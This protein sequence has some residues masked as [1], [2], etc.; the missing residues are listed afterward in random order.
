[1]DSDMVCRRAEFDNVSGVTCEGVT[2]DGRGDTLIHLEPPG[3]VLNVFLGQPISFKCV[4]DYSKTPVTSFRWTHSGRRYS[5][6][7]F[8]KTITSKSDSDN[9][10]CSVQNVAVSTRINV[11]Y[12]PEVHLE[13]K[14][15]TI[16]VGVGEDL[17]VQCVV[18]YA[19]PAVRTFRWSHNGR[20]STG[21]TFLKRDITKSDQGQLTCT[22]DNGHMMTPGRADAT[23]NIKY[24]QEVHLEPSN[25]FI[26]VGVGEDLRVQ[27]VVDYANPAVHTFRW[28]HNGRISTG[29]TFLKRDITKSDQGQLTCTADDGHMMTPG[30]A[31]ATINIKYPPEIH[32]ST[33]RDVIRVT[34]G[35]AVEVECVVDD[36]NPAVSSYMWRHNGDISYGQT[37]LKLVSSSDSGNL[38][39]SATNRQGTSTVETSIT[40]LQA[41]SLS[42]KDK[43]I[44]I[45][46]GS[47]GLAIII[48]LIIFIICQRRKINTAKPIENPQRPA[49][50]PR[51]DDG[52]SQQN[53]ESVELPFGGH[54]DHY[55]EYR[56]SSWI[57]SDT[58]I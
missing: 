40:V 58:V 51:A 5:G 48:I 27:C 3:S 18:D 34:A 53:Y 19:N 25:D 36:A 43:V 42:G 20:T 28:S 2:M 23:I 13:P 39:C 33:R 24:P 16:D 17:R 50:T 9:L 8:S 38:S 56:V 55:R 37:F 26:D 32:L 12:P 15:D 29:S 46:T 45:A 44:A 47:V 21:S 49:S 10:T 1:M 22:A 57:F 30:R 41:S 11:W 6:Q 31:D 35:N 4:I 14:S 54:A 52:G 7:T